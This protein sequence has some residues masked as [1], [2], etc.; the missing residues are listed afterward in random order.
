[1]HSDWLIN[2]LNKQGFKTDLAMSGVD[3]LAMLGLHRTAN[4]FA[5][6][7]QVQAVGLPIAKHIR[8]QTETLNID[9]I[10]QT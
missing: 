5:L 8:F 3:V 1:M 7:R 4:F 9:K 2:M 6:V 10:L